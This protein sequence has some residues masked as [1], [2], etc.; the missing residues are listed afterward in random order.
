MV[1]ERSR[2]VRTVPVECIKPFLYIG[3]KINFIKG[4]PQKTQQKNE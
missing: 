3:I 2:G 1:G 4:I